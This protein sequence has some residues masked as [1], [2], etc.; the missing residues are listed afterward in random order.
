VNC[1]D[2]DQATAYCAWAGKRLPSE[3]ERE[4]AAR[5]AEQGAK[6]PWGSDDPADQ[7]CWNGGTVR[8]SSRN[9]GTCEVGSFPAGDSP[10]GLKDLAGNVWEW[11]STERP[12][13]RRSAQVSASAWDS[14][15]RVVRG[16]SWYNGYSWFFPAANRSAERKSYRKDYLG[17]RCAKTP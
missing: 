13:E 3:E 9:L 8:R 4:W 2:W 12:G 5:G 11:T 1:V 17:F 16:G 10:Q 14:T 7:L 6:Y 15:D